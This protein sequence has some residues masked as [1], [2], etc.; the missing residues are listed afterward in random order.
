MI[1]IAPVTGDEEARNALQTGPIIATMEDWED[2][3]RFY[4]GGVYRHAS[5]VGKQLHTIEV[6]GFDS[7]SWI[8]KNSWGTSWGEK[9][10]ARIAFGECNLFKLAAFSFDPVLT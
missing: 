2:F 5:G 8:V 10:F 7:E 1:N 6:V 3:H 4:G 9:G